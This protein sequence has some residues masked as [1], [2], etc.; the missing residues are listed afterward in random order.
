MKLD[1]KTLSLRI[2]LIAL[3]AFVAIVCLNKMNEKYDPLARYPYVNDENRQVIL[4]HLDEK[5]IDYMITQQIK[6]D[7]YLEFINEPEFSIYNTL[8][9]SK[10]KKTQDASNEYIVNFINKYKGNFT[11]ESLSAYLSHYSYADLTAFYEN[12]QVLHQDVHLVQDP[13]DPTLILNA[14]L[15]VY[16]YVPADLISIQDVF[17]KKDILAGLE[18]MQKD[19]AKMMEDEDDLAIETGYLSYEQVLDQYLKASI[20][21]GQY[22]DQYVFSGGEDEQQLGYTVV[23]KGGMKWNELVAQHKAFLENDYTA[24]EEELD[25][26]ELEKINWIRNNAWRYGFIVRYPQGKEEQTG[27]YYQPYLVRYVGRSNAKKMFDE[28]KVMEEMKFEEELQ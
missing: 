12:E 13:S 20:V 7:Q 2:V 26:K 22:V 5:E 19:Y 1:K 21:Y 24:L 11:L 25:E 14:H 4:D 3:C 10:A 15:S 18:A 16:R 27:H 9:Y 17:V 8:Y 23:L 6:P 28:N